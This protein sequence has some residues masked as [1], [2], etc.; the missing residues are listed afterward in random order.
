MIQ[1][2]IRH[3]ITAFSAI[4]FLL[5]INLACQEKDLS[6]EADEDYINQIL[7]ERKDKD[8]FMREDPLSPFNRNEKI[9]FSPLRYF[10]PDPRFVF[11]SKL[12]KYETSDSVFI[13]GTRGE[14]R[15]AIIEGYL[16]FNYEGKEFRV[17]VYKSFSRNAEPFY[18][19]WFTDRTTGYETYGIGRFLDFHLELDPD[20]IYTLDFNKAYNPY[21]AYNSI[22]TSPIPREEDYLDLEIK[23]GEKNFK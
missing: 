9:E 6:V 16:K 19:I 18:S 3:L 20:H 22:Y 14:Y 17:N 1:N 4:V 13:W 11:K 8:D 2:R 5:I 21:T 12:Y 23:A 7:K 15:L 10:D